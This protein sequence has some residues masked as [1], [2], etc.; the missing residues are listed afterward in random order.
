MAFAG[1]F[2]TPRENFHTSEGVEIDIERSEED[3]AIVIQ[4]L[5]T[6]YRMN[7]DDLYTNKLFIPPILKE[8]V[9]IN[10]FDMIKRMPGQDPFQSPDFRA[11]VIMK[12]MKGMRKV[13]RK[14][15]RT[16]ELQASQV[17][18]T[19][20][21]TLSDINGNALYTL[22]FKPKATHFPT[23]S[24][25]WGTGTEDKAKDISD[26]AEVIRNDGKLDPNELWFGTNAFREWLRDADIQALLDNRRISIGEVVAREPRN[27]GSTYR[28]TIQIDNYIYDMY[29]YNGKYKNP[30]GGAIT[31]Y[32]DEDNV[33]VKSSDSRFD[34]T[35]GAIPNLNRDLGIQQAVVPEMPTRFS[36]AEQGVDLFTN[37]WVTPDG[38]QMFAGVGARP[39]CIPTAIDTYG[40]LKTKA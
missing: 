15:M 28:G 10:A 39:L 27:D 9:A 33:V 26:L 29:T 1:M 13:S 17:L 19:G 18:Q 23:V 3:I 12:A 25:D 5:S 22:D 40:C 20:I 7:S 36:S 4:D 24:I 38:E 11:N 35:Y 37:V 14:V 8:A 34:L 32:M 30:N 16:I 21:I 31:P 6:G 2:R